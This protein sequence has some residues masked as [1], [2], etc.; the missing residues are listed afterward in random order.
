MQLILCLGEIYSFKHISE[1]KVSNNLIFHHRKIGERK[2]TLSPKQTEEK[3][4]IRVEIN[5]IEK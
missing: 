2:S 4:N 3:S 1:Q 5:E